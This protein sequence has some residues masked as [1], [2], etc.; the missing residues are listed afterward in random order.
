[1]DGVS[2]P[3]L[4]VDTSAKDDEIQPK[5]TL[6]PKMSNSDNMTNESTTYASSSKRNEMN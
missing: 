2:K 5:K 6:S 3:S 1:M 4:N